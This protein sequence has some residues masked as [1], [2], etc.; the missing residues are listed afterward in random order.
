MAFNHA[1][2]TYKRTG[3]NIVSSRQHQQ[4]RGKDI[5]GPDTVSGTSFAVSNKADLPSQTQAEI[6]TCT[7]FRLLPTTTFIMQAIFFLAVG[8]MSVIVVH[9]MYGESAP[10][11]I[12]N[13]LLSAKQAEEWYL[14][15]KYQT[16]ERKDVRLR[17]H[18]TEAEKM[19]YA[20]HSVREITANR[21]KR[22]QAED[23]QFVVVFD[24]GST[25]TRVHVYEFH[26]GDDGGVQLIKEVYQKRKPGLSDFAD[27]VDG[28]ASNIQPLIDIALQTVPEEKRSST[29]LVFKATGGFRLLPEEKADNLLNK[30]RDTLHSTNLLFDSEDVDMI[31]GTEEGL[32]GWVT[33]NY[34]LGFPG[35]R[36]HTAAALDLG[37]ASVQVTFETR[38]QSIY[39]KDDIEHLDVLGNG[40]SLYTHSYLGQGL[41]EA[42][43]STLEDVGGNSLL[44]FCL[45]AGY[46]GVLTHAGITYTLIGPEESSPEMCWN[47]VGDYV[48]SLDITPLDELN[49]PGWDVY[50]FSYFYD[51]LQWSGALGDKQTKKVMK[52]NDY[53][54]LGAQAC[55]NPDV[56]EPFLCQDLIYITRL[57][58]ERFLI[59]QTQLHVVS[60]INSGETSWALGAGLLALSDEDDDDNNQTDG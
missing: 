20:K 48:L 39:P 51:V 37:G 59:T 21:M 60:Q 19:I 42:R 4:Q 13:Q 7:Q 18:H 34:L 12:E 22:L 55:G 26:Q 45:P 23:D 53:L 1:G 14:T 17:S 25:G 52:V 27:D 15:K 2:E 49:E 44:G 35:E 30:V 36:P 24:A 54:Q 46:S 38:D 56:N 8:V 40:Y 6:R 9:Q 11:P 3:K 57:L 28:A 41:K 50:L 31:S 5:S 58:G 43:F 16:R 29:P 32:F 10:Q 47:Q 33:I